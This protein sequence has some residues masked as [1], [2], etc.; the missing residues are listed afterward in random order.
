M[1]FAIRRDELEPVNIFAIRRD[2][3]EH[4]SYAHRLDT[5]PALNLCGCFDP[6]R[7][8]YVAPLDE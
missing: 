4:V 6:C 8:S 3:L 5:V 2:A 1:H 7:L